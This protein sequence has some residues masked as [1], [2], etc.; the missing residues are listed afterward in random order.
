MPTRTIARLTGL[1]AVSCLAATVQP[2]SA[3]MSLQGGPSN[4]FL[5]RQ[6]A[7]ERE[8]D[9]KLQ[10]DLPFDQ[11]FQLD[12]GGWYN[13]Y[14]FLFDDGVDSSRTLRQYEFRLWTSFSADQGVHTGY[15]RMRATFDD[16]NHGDSFTPNEDDLDGPN[17]ERGWYQFDVAKA[18]RVHGS[19]NPWYELNIKMG[20]DLI[21]AGTGYAINLPLDHVQI[22]GQALNFQT[23]MLLGKVPASTPNIDQSRSVSDHSDRRFWILEER[24]KGLASHEPF[25]YVAW[26]E[27]DTREDPLD[28]LQNYTYDSTYIGFGSTGELIQNLRYSSE[29]VIERGESYGNNRYLYKD[30]VKAWGFDHRLDYYFRHKTK[31]SISVEY[32]F[33]SGDPNRL[34]SPTNAEGGN[35]GDYVDNGFSGFGFRDTGLSFAPRLSNVHVWRT[36][37]SF[38]PL[39]DQQATKN[40]EL[41]TDYY[42]YY[43]NRSR[44]AVSDTTADE[45]SGYLGWEMDYYA[46]YRIFND[47]SW[48]V[49]FGTFF[50]GS[51]FSDQTTRTFLLTGVTWSF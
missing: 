6:R 10:R 34:G 31:P 16:W 19:A 14:F 17:L 42:L 29:W 37:A 38:R 39:P 21:N 5:E 35:R 11:R 26:Q 44:A 20:R 33:A 1:L 45:Q 50:P 41:G 46:N 28:L 43:K 2:V 25:A 49:R 8:N 3:Q 24:Y 18:M 23:T 15:A 32:M 48:T 22:Q 7:L 36:G 13:M 9:R 51:A 47:L 4:A 30:E 27:D 12:F 40:L